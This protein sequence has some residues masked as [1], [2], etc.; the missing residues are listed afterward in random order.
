MVLFCTDTSFCDASD[1]GCF[2]QLARLHLR[3]HND[4]S[5]RAS[6]MWETGPIVLGW[7]DP[8]PSPSLRTSQQEHWSLVVQEWRWNLHNIF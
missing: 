6:T 1:V 3:H 5:W 2:Y 4:V 8:S 7:F